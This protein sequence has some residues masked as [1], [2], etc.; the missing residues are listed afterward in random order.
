M[1]S[2]HA[3][4]GLK[5]NQTLYYFWW[6]SLESRERW[7]LW[8]GECLKLR[9]HRTWN[10][11]PQCGFQTTKPQGK[12]IEPESSGRANSRVTPTLSI[13]LD[14]YMDRKVQLHKIRLL[15]RSGPS[16]PPPAR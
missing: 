10:V 15:M 12:L 2:L 5:D 16:G 6:K 1:Q 3:A 13:S 14:F 8:G 7:N 4:C 9:C 11:I